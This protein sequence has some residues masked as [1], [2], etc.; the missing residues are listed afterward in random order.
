[1]IGTA[2]FNNNLVSFY[3]VELGIGPN[4]NEWI[5]LGETHSEPNVNG[6]LE[7]LVAGAFPPGD[8]ALRLVV[9][10]KDGNYVGEPHVIPIVIE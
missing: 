6:V 7:T 1:V 4:P 10:L 2:D 9:I 3:K 5:T 8:Y